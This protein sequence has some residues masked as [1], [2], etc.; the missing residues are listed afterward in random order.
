MT[1]ETKTE[2][3]KFEDVKEAPFDPSNEPRNPDGTG[4]IP[5]E[6]GKM[7]KL[8][9][10]LNEE[11]GEDTVEYDDDD[12]GSGFVSVNGKYK[13]FIT[14]CSATTSTRIKA[15]KTKAI[16]S[17]Y[18]MLKSLLLVQEDIE[19]K[20]FGGNLFSNVFYEPGNMRNFEH[21]CISSKCRAFTKDGK[22]KY[23]PQA[24]YEKGGSVG[25]P[26]IVEVEMEWQDKVKKSDLDGK[27]YPEM[28]DGGN[29]IKIKRANVIAYYPWDT[30]K[31]YTSPEETADDIDTGI[32]DDDLNLDGDNF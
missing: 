31:R 10:E 24:S 20:K 1:P 32:T 23:F 13:C 18:H 29:P 30:T 16:G 7:D 11:F 2:D 4:G 19:G 22:R 3:V 15:T 12:L 26:I 27:Y 6:D 28:D 8:F 9:A 17:V 21:F 5:S 14:E 25:M